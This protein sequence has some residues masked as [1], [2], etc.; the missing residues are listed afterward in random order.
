MRSAPETPPGGVPGSALRVL[1]G[2]EP[3]ERRIAVKRRPR[4]ETVDYVNGVLACDRGVLG[5]TLTLME[6][7]SPAH[8]RQAGEVLDALMPRTGASLRVGV[9]GTPGV[10]KSTFIEAVGMM[11]V[12]AGRRVAVVAVDP[13]S[14]ATGG[15]ILGD[16]TRM[17]RLSMSPAAMV[18]PAP[19]GGWLGGVAR[20]TRESILVLE[21]AG[22]DVVIVETVGVGQSET[23][24]SSMVDFFL[25]LT[26]P[27]AGDELQGMKRGIMEVAHGIVVNKADGPILEAAKVARAQVEGALRLMRPPADGWRP[28]AAT[29]SAATG[30]G[31]DEVWR[32]VEE[33]Q[34]HLL[35][36]H[37]LAPRRAEQAALWMRQAF[38]HELAARFRADAARAE[39]FDA[40]SARVR[41]GAA[42]PLA[43][44][45]ELLSLVYPAPR[46][47]GA[48]PSHGEPESP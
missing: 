21:A 9:T 26:M 48:A 43:A 47:G 7:A 10:G 4:L 11:L 34:R 27:G 37:Q 5:R 18:R 36:T 35:D 16:K 6:S 40:L 39:R 46:E 38:E 41:A 44:A 1:P 17:E 42:S 2:A 15:S 8:R 19:S 45:E 31:L 32:M 25:L 20:G 14:D 22:Y 28:R 33:R 23:L 13:S 29:C 30:A 3:S 12:E 24:V